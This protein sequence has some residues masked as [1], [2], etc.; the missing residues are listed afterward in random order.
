MEDVRAIKRAVESPPAAELAEFRSWFVE[1]DVGAWQVQDIAAGL[2]EADRGE[3]A[4]PDKVTSFFA[5]H[6]CSGATT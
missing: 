4:S 6:G 5:R 1:S 3:F 2:A